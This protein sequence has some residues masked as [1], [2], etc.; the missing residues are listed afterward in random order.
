MLNAK[1]LEWSNNRPNTGGLLLEDFLHKNGL[2]CVND[3]HP[4]RRL[5]DSLID[6]YI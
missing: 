6:L 4:T 1:S 3:G 2:L 5:S